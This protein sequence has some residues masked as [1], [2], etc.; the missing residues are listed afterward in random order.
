MVYLMGKKVFTTSVSADE[1]GG[2]GGMG[3]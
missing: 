3:E 2:L 1:K